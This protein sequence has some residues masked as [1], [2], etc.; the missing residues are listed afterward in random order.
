M[1][2]EYIL[3]GQGYGDVATALL[4]NNFDTGPLRPFIGKNGLPYQTLNVNGKKQTILALNA[5][6]T[7]RKDEW[8]MIDDTVTDA[9]YTTAMRMFADLRARGDIIRIPNGMGKTIYEYQRM[10]DIGP[11]TTSM[12]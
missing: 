7:L 5:P 12:D 8:K 9:V 2:Q 1:M 6:A 11:A 4:A 3:N 10:T